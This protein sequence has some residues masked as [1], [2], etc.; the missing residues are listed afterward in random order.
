[1]FIHFQ[2]S[3][4]FRPNSLAAMEGFEKKYFQPGIF[5]SVRMRTDDRLPDKIIRY[6][7]LFLRVVNVFVLCHF[8]VIV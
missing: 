4:P 3:Y 5:V 6:P 8:N 1:M 7:Y 2:Y